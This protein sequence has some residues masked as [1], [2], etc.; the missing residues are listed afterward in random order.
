LQEVAFDTKITVKAGKKSL[1][2]INGQK[3]HI[4]ETVVA[5]SFGAMNIVAEEIP[6]GVNEED[7]FVSLLEVKTTSG[8]IVAF[9]HVYAGAGEVTEYGAN[10][11]NVLNDKNKNIVVTTGADAMITLYGIKA[12]AQRGVKA[13]ALVDG[14][15][16]YSDGQTFTF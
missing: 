2:K 14:V 16:I 7:A 3:Y 5:Y 6:A 13:Y 8:E 12:G 9:V 10:F 4:G 15:A 1:W 11:W